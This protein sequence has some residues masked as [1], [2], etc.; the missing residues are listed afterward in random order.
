MRLLILHLLNSWHFYAAFDYDNVVSEHFVGLIPFSKEV[1]TH[2]SAVNIMEVLERFF[3][4]MDIPIKNAR[5]ACMDTT[6]VNSGEKTGLKRLLEH[7]I[8]LL[9]WIGCNNHKLALCFKHL[10]PQ[11]SCIFDADVFPL[12]LWKFFK[13]HTL[14]LTFVEDSAEMYGDD[15]M[16]PVCTS[17]TRWTAHEHA[18]LAFFKSF[19]HILNA[20][21]VSCRERN[22]SEALGL[23]IHAS[24]SQMIAMILML[25]EIFQCIHPLILSLQ[26]SLE[27][28]CIS[29]VKT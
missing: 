4:N 12:N 7:D 29:E 8:P 24:S 13:Y 26:K 27:S 23:I 10:I 16:K 5:F 6:N 2:L 28:L 20:L 17:G 11:F 15:V 9:K 21:I 14:S 19:S 25:L 3:V 1:G 22:E 18:C